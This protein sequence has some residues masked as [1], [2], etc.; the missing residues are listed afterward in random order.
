MCKIHAYMY[1]Q[2]TIASVGSLRL[3]PHMYLLPV[4]GHSGSPH[5]C[6]YCQ[7]GVTQALPTHVHTASV[8]SLRLSPHIYSRFAMRLPHD[9]EEG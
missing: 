7:C 8:G 2:Y 1:I 4:W 5:T 6:T 3:S 9:L